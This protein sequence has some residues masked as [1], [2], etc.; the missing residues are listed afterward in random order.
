MESNRD[1]IKA[2]EGLTRV[3]IA[4]T[5]GNKREQAVVQVRVALSRIKRSAIDLD[6]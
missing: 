5:S 6:L 2:V 1:L 4:V 3:L